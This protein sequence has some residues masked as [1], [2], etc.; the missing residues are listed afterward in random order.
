MC[1]FKLK[2]IKQSIGD[3]FDDVFFRIFIEATQRQ[4]IAHKFGKYLKNIC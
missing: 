2:K 3:I 1:E 4:G